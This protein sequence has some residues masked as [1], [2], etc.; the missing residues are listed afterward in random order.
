MPQHNGIPD[1]NL[2]S[3]RALV[4]DDYRINGEI[5][6]QYLHTWGMACDIV[7]SGEEAYRTASNAVTT[8]RGYD[9]IFVDYHMGDMNGLQFAEKVRQSPIL[10]ECIL[11]LVTSVTNVAPAEALKQKGFAGSLT[12][13]FYPEQLKAILQ[14]AVDAKTYKKNIGLITRHYVTSI[15]H[16][17]HQRSSEEFRQYPQKRA[18]VVE[19][20]K[21]NQMLITKLLEKHG[22]RVDTAANGKES[23]EIMSQFEYD[24]TFMDCQMP[25]MDGFEATAAIREIEAKAHKRHSVIVALTADAM[26]GDREKCLKAGM[27]DYLNKP[28]RFHEVSLILEKWLGNSN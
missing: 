10:A 16:D 9:V 26:I 2:A 19:D 7:T 3:Y 18:L 17:K 28:I 14:I 4:V 24:I 6:Y 12:K 27:D 22:M 5:L 20:V 21:V 1:V 13:P 25:V 11:I 15:L 8:G 23:V